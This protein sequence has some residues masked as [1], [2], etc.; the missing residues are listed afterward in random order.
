VW[1]HNDPNMLFYDLLL[2]AWKGFGTSATALRS[3][4]V[5][6]FVAAAVMVYILARHLFCL[7]VGL[8]S[9]LLMGV[10]TFGVTYAQTARSYALLLF[11]S[12]AASY[13]FIRAIES[14]SKW[15]WIAYVLVGARF[16]DLE[17]SINCMGR[18]DTAC[19]ALSCPRLWFWNQSD[20]LD[21]PHHAY[22]YFKCQL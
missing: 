19:R 9:G 5:V 13:L 21:P 14:E 18:V 8:T 15:W 2:H 4:S 10:S 12:V 17:A 22:P 6:F 7:G 1:I 20:R 3:L 16:C 11:L